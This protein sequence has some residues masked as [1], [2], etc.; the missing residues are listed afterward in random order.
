RHPDGL[1][2]FSAKP[3]NADDGRPFVAVHASEDVS[4]DDKA[5]ASAVAKAAQAEPEAAP[6]WGKILY[7]RN[8]MGL[9]DTSKVPKKDSMG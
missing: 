1:P 8:P 6:A 7:Y 4:F 2:Q 9:P 3:R 5:K